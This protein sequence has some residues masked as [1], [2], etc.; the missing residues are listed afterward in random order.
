MSL[1]REEETK[2]VAKFFFISPDLIYTQ[3]VNL[4]FCNWNFRS[5][6]ELSGTDFN[7]KNVYF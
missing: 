1:E 5:G 3:S 4:I 7:L 6:I 2:V